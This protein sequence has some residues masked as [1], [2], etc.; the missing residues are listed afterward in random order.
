MGKREKKHS[1]SN[2][3]LSITYCI[4]GQNRHCC[5]SC[6]FV[7]L[8]H[9]HCSDDV[10][11]VSDLHWRCALWRAAASLPPHWGHADHTAASGRCPGGSSATEGECCCCST[12][13]PRSLP[14][15]HWSCRQ[16]SETEEEMW[17]GEGFSTLMY[18][19]NTAWFIHGINWSITH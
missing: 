19:R 2:C 6:L 8:W 9:R 15:W 4:T 13:H 18:Y 12:A 17:S 16:E 10:N 11:C 5:T 14:G 3:S 7:L 1:F